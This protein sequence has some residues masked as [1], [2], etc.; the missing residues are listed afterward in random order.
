[1]NSIYSSKY[2]F[3]I[4]LQSINRTD[5]SIYE[6]PAILQRWSIMSSNVTGQTLISLSVTFHVKR[7]WDPYWGSWDPYL[8]IWSAK[9]LLGAEIAHLVK[10]LPFKGNNSHNELSKNL[11]WKSDFGRPYHEDHFVHSKFLS[12]YHSFQNNGWNMLKTLFLVFQG[13]L[14]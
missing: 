11:D 6:N 12:F 10:F 13:Q 5:S 8:I 14:L 3:L 4:L 2:Q 7:R 1:M 9:R